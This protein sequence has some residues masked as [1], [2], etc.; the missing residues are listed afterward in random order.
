MRK[1]TKAKLRGI[2][3]VLIVVAAFIALITVLA[4]ALSSKDSENPY[5]EQSPELAATPAPLAS[6]APEPSPTPTVEPT[7]VVEYESLGEFTLTA[8]CP[9]VQCCGE[10]SAEHPSRVGTDYIQ[11]TFSGTI[12]EQGRTLSVD[13][14]V[15]PFG[16]TV[17]INGHEYI[18]ED[19]GGA[20]KGNRAD[21]YFDSH[22]AALEFGR[23]T[24]EVFIKIIKED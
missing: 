2:I 12:P 19:S 14:E 17:V 16:T 11:K 3:A 21:V 24:A 9:C 8:Y 15:I 4:N 23:Q 10:W 6:L 5:D 20:I 18:A 22:D 1:K 7:P 13:P